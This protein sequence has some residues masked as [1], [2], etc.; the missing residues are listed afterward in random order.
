MST[1][2]NPRFPHAS[3]A[4]IEVSKNIRI[5]AQ[6]RAQKY[7]HRA[8]E[9]FR[10][11][12]YNEAI[13]ELKDAIQNDPYQSDYHAWMAKVQ[14]Q[15]GLVSIAAI[16]VRQAL[17]LNP[18]DALALECQKQ[19]DAKQPPKQPP[20]PQNQKPTGISGFLTKKIF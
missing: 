19:I 17:N 18:N 10:L 6:E 5:A 3:T 20:M 1:P 9:Q 13:I 4:P 7:L 2:S 16:S 11:Q 8:Q 12:R 14:L 15:R